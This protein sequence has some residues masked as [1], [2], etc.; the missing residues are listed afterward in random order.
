MQAWDAG[1]R[2]PSLRFSSR[3]RSCNHRIPC[4]QKGLAKFLTIQTVRDNPSFCEPPSLRFVCDR[5]PGKTLPHWTVRT[6]RI[7]GRRFPLPR[8]LVTR[9]TPRKRG[10]EH[11][12]RSD[13]TSGAS[14]WA[15][16]EVQRHGPAEGTLLEPPELRQDESARQQAWMAGIGGIGPG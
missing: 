4:R 3:Y 11:G 1:A 10:A 5:S 7:K 12:Y 8:R 9:L 6:S 15:A 2:I 14:A 13:R 16:P